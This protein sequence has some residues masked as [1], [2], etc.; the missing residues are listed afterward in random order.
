MIK[1]SGKY[2]L[3]KGSEEKMLSE[4]HSNIKLSWKKA[5]NKR[6][7]FQLERLLVI[8]KSTAVKWIGL[9]MILVANVGLNLLDLFI[10]A[11]P[12]KM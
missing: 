5:M 10:S 3:K 6:L 4:D 12:S 2:N 7:D 8:M 11:S 9:V 1:A